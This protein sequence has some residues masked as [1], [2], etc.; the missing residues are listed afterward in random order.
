M[1]DQIVVEHQFHSD[2]PDTGDN[3]KVQA[4]FWNTPLKVTLAGIIKGLSTLSA[5]AGQIPVMTGA[6]TAGVIDTSPFTR[7]LFNLADGPA[8]QSAIGVLGANIYQGT[9]NASTNSPALVSGVGTK[10]FYYKVGTAGT[11]TIN[12]LSQW[13][14]G[15]III[16][17]GATWDKIDGLSTEVLSVAGRVGAVVLGV[18]DVSGLGY[19]ATGTDAANLT[20]T[21][22]SA[23]LSGAYEGIAGLGTLTGNLQVNGG[24]GV[25]QPVGSG[26]DIIGSGNDAYFY[27]RR[28]GS[29]ILGTN[30]ATVLS[31][32]A[33]GAVSIPVSLAIGGASGVHALS[34]YGGPGAAGPQALF[35]QDGVSIGGMLSN[36]Q[37]NGGTGGDFALV[38]GVGRG[39]HFYTNDGAVNVDR[40]AITS[41]GNVG[42]GTTAPAVR[43]QVGA[44][45]A[46][47]SAI[48]TSEIWG[49]SKIT[50][51]AGTLNIYSTDA[52]AIDKGGSIG[53]GG[54]NASS[55]YLYGKIAGRSESGI[56]YAGYLQFSTTTG[57]GGLAERL[58]ITSTGNVGIGTNNPGYL[59]DVNGTSRFVGA[60]IFSGVTTAPTQSPGDNST[61]LATTAY[62][63]AAMVAATTLPRSYLAGLI[64]SNNVGTPNSEIDVSAGTCRDDSNSV[65]ITLAAG[66]IDCGTTGANGLVSGA[67]ANSTWYHAFAIAKADG[68]VA[69]LAS[70]SLAPTLPTG[71]IYKRRLG[72]FKTDGAAHILAFTQF[73]DQV[74]WTTPI[75]DLSVSQGT[76]VST[77]TLVGVPTGIKV[78]AIICADIYQT[79][80]ALALIFSADDTG[81]TAVNSPSGN[82]NLSCP[83]NTSAAGQLHLRTNTSAQIKAVASTAATTL[84]VATCGW[85]D[86]RGRDD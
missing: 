40:M 85:I 59:L 36:S 60:A 33:S 3:T 61:K 43:L 45:T 73:G 53:L 8:W 65:N 32:I 62:A 9:W 31:A 35:Y 15:D 14:A 17:N 16:F 23:R 5:S 70:T 1:T 10:G 54:P 84:Q 25:G 80:P 6:D 42:I 79:V 71:Y 50:D 18:G 66:T 68:T 83:A 82:F 21:L 4:S 22:A 58:R 27:N 75:A 49:P 81:T 39:L 76:G 13:N 44:G 77:W 56:N 26:L 52:L 78:I 38:T 63:D 30:N 72:S 55:T 41:G 2:K 37:L 34:I 7:A 51:A 74:L 46:L 47:D 11:T 57:P 28:A 69:R 12:G 64:L 67:L 48:V 20:G 29:L 24:I 86:P 19:F